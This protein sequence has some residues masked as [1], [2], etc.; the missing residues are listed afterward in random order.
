[1]KSIDKYYAAFKAGYLGTNVLDTYF[2]FVANIILENKYTTIEDASIRNAIMERYDIELPLTFI[3]QV[4]S[5]GVE[6]NCFVE[7]RGK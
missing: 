1:M 2:S 3:R 5:V 7:N 6:H 4:L